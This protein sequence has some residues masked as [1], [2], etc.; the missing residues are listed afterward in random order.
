MHQVSSFGRDPDRG[1]DWLGLRPAAARRKRVVV[2]PGETHPMAQL[3]GAGLITRV[4]MTTLL[5]LRRRA[6][7]DLV[8]RFAW[9]GEAQPSVECPFGDF[10][11]APFGREVAYDAAPM[12]IVGGG[13]LSRWPMPYAAGA[14]LEILN[15]GNATID[16][17]FYQVTYHELDAPAALPRE[18][19]AREPDAVRRALHRRRGARRRA[20]RRLPRRPAEPRVVAASRSARGRV[21]ARLRPGDARGSGA[22]LGGRR[23]DR[24]AAGH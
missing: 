13:F 2:A 23:G 4:W 16:P 24:L 6:L 1:G 12:G 15:D 21:P 17:L 19:A 7:R 20:L 3:P 5:P 22:H 18:L 10:F 11:G 14:R 9:D 8:L